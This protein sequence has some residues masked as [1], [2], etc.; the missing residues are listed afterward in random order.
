MF[1]SCSGSAQPCATGASMEFCQAGFNNMCTS[2]FYQVGNQTFP[3][4][5]CTDTASCQQEAEVACGPSIIDA[6]PPPADTGPPDAPFFDAPFDDGGSVTCTPHACGTMGQTMVF[7]ESI[8]PNNVC[9]AA[10]FDVAGQMF[11]CNSCTDC[12]IAAQEASKAC[13]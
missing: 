7:C 3:C 8:D 6:G 4:T 9:T 1:Q 5:S 2:A 11:D 12:T 10:W 13:P